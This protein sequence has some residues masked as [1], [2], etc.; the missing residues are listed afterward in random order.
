MCRY[1][2]ANG[3]QAR[4]EKRQGGESCVLDVADQGG[5]TLSEVGDLMGITSERVRQIEALALV[6]MRK[7]MPTSSSG[8]DP[9]TEH[10]LA[11]A[12]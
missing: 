12:V 7:R 5:S 9:Y 10:P 6:R 8:H 11:K 1:H 2:M 3:M 4:N